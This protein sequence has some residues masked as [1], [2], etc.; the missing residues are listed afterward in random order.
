MKHKIGRGNKSIAEYRKS[1]KEKPIEQILTPAAPEG[2]ELKLELYEKCEDCA[3]SGA[4]YERDDNGDPYLDRCFKCNGEGYIKFIPAAPPRSA[5]DR[6][7][8]VFGEPERF[9]SI[10]E[11]ILDEIH[12]SEEPT[13]RSAEDLIRGA[14]GGCTCSEAYTSRNKT[15]P[16]CFYCN[17]SDDI[18]RIMHAYASQFTHKQDSK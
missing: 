8:V 10:D 12:N 1:L 11:R 3:G 17:H 16:Y 14:F 4:V 2:R 5:E 6:P 9:K 15:D 13:I 18:K 7:I